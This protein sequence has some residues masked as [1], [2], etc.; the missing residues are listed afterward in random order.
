VNE[1]MNFKQL[2]LKTYSFIKNML[3]EAKEM[4]KALPCDT[5]NASA[6]VHQHKTNQTDCEVAVR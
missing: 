2:F 5:L 6:M 1:D 3:E 4:K